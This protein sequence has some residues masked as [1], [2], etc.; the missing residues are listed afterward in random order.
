M[1]YYYGE[2]PRTESQQLNRQKLANAVIA[3]RNL[4]NIQKRYYNELAIGKD[5]SGY[6]IFIAEWIKSN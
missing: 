3:W 6:N 2:N 5:K 4:T 1:R